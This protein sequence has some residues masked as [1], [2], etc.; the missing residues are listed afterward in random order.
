MVHGLS[1]KRFNYKYDEKGTK[2]LILKSL[3]LTFLEAQIA[4]ATKG[5][6]VWNFVETQRPSRRRDSRDTWE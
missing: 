1:I 6:S 5:E 4:R 2:S 3:C